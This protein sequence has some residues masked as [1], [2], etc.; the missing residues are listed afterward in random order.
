[1]YVENDDLSPLSYA[2]IVRKNRRKKHMCK[3]NG[4]YEFSDKDCEF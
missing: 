1:M 4:F 3:Y 2:L